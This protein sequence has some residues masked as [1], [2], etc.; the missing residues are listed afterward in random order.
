MLFLFHA[1]LSGS[2]NNDMGHHLTPCSSPVLG[3]LVTCLA[4]ELPAPPSVLSL[5]FSNM[6]LK[7]ESLDLLHLGSCFLS[8]VSHLHFVLIIGA[9]S[10]GKYVHL[11][12]TEAEKS[13]AFNY[14][15]VIRYWIII[16]ICYLELT[17]SLFSYL[18][19]IK[20]VFLWLQEGWFVEITRYHK[21]TT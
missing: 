7:Q 9:M 2:E 12:P 20:L 19:M 8:K 18:T 14:C 17:W 11:W 6:K 3:V 15:F 5:T 1:S 13:H 21:K 10:L 16:V 4:L